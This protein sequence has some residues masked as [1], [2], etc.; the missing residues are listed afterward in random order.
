MYMR[1]VAGLLPPPDMTDQG[2]IAGNFYVALAENDDFVRAELC[3]P[4]YRE[5]HGYGPEDTVVGVQSLTSAGVPIYTVGDS[6]DD[7][8]WAISRCFAD[9]LGLWGFV[10]AH[11]S[12]FYPLLIL[13]PSVARSLKDFGWTKDRIR[14]DIWEDLWMRVE[15]AERYAPALGGGP[16]RLTEGWQHGE[17]ARANHFRSDPEPMAR[18]LLRPDL[19]QIVIAGSPG[20]NQSK[21][22]LQ[23]NRQG[24]PTTRKVRVI[25][26]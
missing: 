6:A 4:T 19:I 22:F 10:G 15:D 14:K 13:G 12:V 7:V 1:N 24:P 26:H 3:W 21:A 20:R 5:D 2:A 18:M 9:T 17:A 16:R 25:P 8:I 11:G 23:Q